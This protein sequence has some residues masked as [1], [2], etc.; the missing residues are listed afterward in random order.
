M[1]T[2]TAEHTFQVVTVADH[3]QQRRVPALSASAT[4]RRT[5]CA[6]AAVSL[7]S[8]ASPLSRA[9]SARTRHKTS[10]QN[11]GL[12]LIL[13]SDLGRRSLHI[14]KHTCSSCGYPAAKI[15][16]CMPSSQTSWPLDNP[17]FTSARELRISNI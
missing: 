14:Q 10:I 8:S 6:D 17:D 12:L 15:R 5:L 2:S 3:L 1:S 4:T 11:S 16:Q 7:R 9:H 13:P